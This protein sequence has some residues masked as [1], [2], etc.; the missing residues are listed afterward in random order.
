MSFQKDKII[1]NCLERH[2]GDPYN[3]ETSPLISIANQWTGFYMIGTYVIRQF[4]KIS[5][6]FKHV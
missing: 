2:E 4:K 3:V 5:L 1:A 6:Y